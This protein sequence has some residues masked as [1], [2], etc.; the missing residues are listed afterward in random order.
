MRTSGNEGEDV[1]QGLGRE[2]IYA[3]GA[4]VGRVQVERNVLVVLFTDFVY[5]LALGLPL[6]LLEHSLHTS[7]PK[8]RKPQQPRRR[9][10]T[11]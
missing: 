7:E 9:R 6:L 8:V 3:T 10:K 1:Q 11:Y 4:V 2:F 5:E